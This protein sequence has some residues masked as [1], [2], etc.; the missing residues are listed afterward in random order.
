MRFAVGARAC[1]ANVFATKLV[2]NR[3]GGEDEGGTAKRGVL[4]ASAQF[5]SKVGV[6]RA[7]DAAFRQTYAALG[8]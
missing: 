8:W 7:R 4:N 2:I 5:G 6:P 1:F 3:T